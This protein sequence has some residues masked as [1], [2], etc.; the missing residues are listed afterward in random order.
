MDIL[1]TS[2]SKERMMERGISEEDIQVLLQ[3][4]VLLK[5]R[6]K[7]DPSVILL[8]GYSRKKGLVLILDEE[9]WR[10]ITVRR[11]R[12]DEKKLLE[13]KGIYHD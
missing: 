10:L 4:K 12:K 3:S 6:S 13:N 9:S 5:A 11:L 8:M 1:Y 7:S 2:H